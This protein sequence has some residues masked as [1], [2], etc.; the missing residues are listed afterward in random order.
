MAMDN[1]KKLI[2]AATLLF[3]VGTALIIIRFTSPE[4]TWTCQN[5]VW[6]KHGNPSNAKPETGCGDAINANLA[7]SSRNSNSVSV[8]SFAEC[9]AAGNPIMES[10]PRQCTAN[11]KSFTEDIGNSLDQDD[12]IRVTTPRPNGT[13]TSP[14]TITGEAR[15]QWFFEAQF[16]I[17]LVDSIG[18]VVATATARAQGEWMTENFVPFTAEITF[19]NPL[20]S[21][22]QLLLSND[23]PSGINALSNSLYFPIIFSTNQQKEQ[24]IKVFFGNNTLGSNGDCVTVYPINRT[25]GSTVAVARAAIDQLLAGPK[26]SEKND[27]YFSNIAAGTTVQSINIID[28]TATVDFSKELD[29]NSGG[30][31]KVSLI[32]SQ[33][34]Q[35][36][37]QFSTVTK[38]IITVDGEAETALQP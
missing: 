29:E 4:D 25:I 30:S 32:R 21:T 1:H 13:I 37:K 8:Y 31:C 19:T 2:I 5:G 18:T 34:E 22:G 6:V 12:L 28:G 9:A 26:A 11:G 10:Y 15:G 23:N 33:I 38:V 36:L 24:S 3:I 14:L 27:G 7:N 17:T 20:T 35:T 16:P